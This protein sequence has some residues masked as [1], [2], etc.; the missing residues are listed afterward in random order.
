MRTDVFF[1]RPGH[2]Q[3][4][5][6]ENIVKCSCNIIKYVFIHVGEIGI[7]D[8]ECTLINT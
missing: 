8:N 1:V 7:A 4:R 6:I 5:R 2:K 3:I